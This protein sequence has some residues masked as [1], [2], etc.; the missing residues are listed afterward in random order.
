VIDPT[1]QLKGAVTTPMGELVFGHVN[2]VVEPLNKITGAKGE[3][4]KRAPQ[5]LN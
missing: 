2:A 4:V 1:E 3:V 5:L